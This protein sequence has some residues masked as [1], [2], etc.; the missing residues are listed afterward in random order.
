M[1]GGMAILLLCQLAGTV[2]QQAMGLPVP[3]PVIGMVLLLGLL[4]WRGGPSESL[5]GAAQGLLKY[6]GLLFVPAGVGFVTE[7]PEL[8]A[9]AAAIAVS[10]LVSTFLALAVTGLLMQL[11]LRKDRESGAAPGLGG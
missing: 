11:L 4:T 10:I 1:V 5:E 2:L 7:L 8:R 9:N 3:G 6:L